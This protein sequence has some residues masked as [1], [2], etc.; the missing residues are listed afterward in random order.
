M[1]ADSGKLIRCKYGLSAK[2]DLS[3]RCNLDPVSNEIDES[4]RQYEKHDW[5]KYSTGDGI[6]IVV[7]PE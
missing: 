6:T 5:H 1:W 3:I 4:E 2:A 7:N